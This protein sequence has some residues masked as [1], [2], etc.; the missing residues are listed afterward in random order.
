[1][2]TRE[3]VLAGLLALTLVPAC[4]SNEEISDIDSIETDQQENA[5]VD[6]KTDQTVG[7]FTYYSVRQD[8]RRCISP[9]CGGF[10]VKRVNQRYTHCPGGGPRNDP[11]WTTGECYVA[12]ADFG[13]TGISPSGGVWRGSVA[14]KNYGTYGNYRVFNGTEAWTAAGTTEATGIFYRVTDSGIVCITYPCPTHRESKLN[15][16]A[17]S[18]SIAGA[19]LSGAGASQEAQDAAFA[20]MTQP[21]GVLV[22]GTNVTVTGPAG[23]AKSL[24]ATQFFLPVKKAPT[25]YKGG[26]SGQV[27]SDRPDVIT[28]CEWR[29]EYACYQT[30]TCEAQADGSC[31]WTK[32]AD[33]DACLAAARPGYCNADSDCR[34]E[35]DY[36]TGCDCRALSRGESLP[37]CSG[38]GVRCFVQPCLNKT[39]ACVNHACVA[40]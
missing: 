26:C 33:L 28:T 25:C 34:L 35:D 22:A 38:P 13:S 36:C 2:R 29:E 17:A 27:C 19:D 12:T 21:G 31:G 8:L 4:A 18:I 1:V 14:R 10:F 16:T 30:A 39:A 9:L 24:Q 6:G 20:Q 40:Q 11:N 23:S 37:I 32:T 7:N 15:S 3:L 5:A